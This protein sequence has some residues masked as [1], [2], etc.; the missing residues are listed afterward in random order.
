MIETIVID[1]INRRTI[2]QQILSSKDNHMNI[3]NQND[4]LVSDV[5]SDTISKRVATNLI[6]IGRPPHEVG[7]ILSNKTETPKMKA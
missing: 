5:S 7:S 6:T 3:Q 2:L 4:D 1:P